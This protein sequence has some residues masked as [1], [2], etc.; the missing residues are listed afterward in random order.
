M[1]KYYKKKEVAGILGCCEKTI[2]NYSKSG[3]LKMIKINARKI[4][5]PESSVFNLLMEVQNET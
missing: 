3:K 2:D 5:I 4:L 1:E